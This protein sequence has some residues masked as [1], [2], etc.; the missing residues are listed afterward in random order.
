MSRKN[1]RR[2]GVKNNH[3]DHGGAR[4][5][6]TPPREISEEEFFQNLGHNINVMLNGPDVRPESVK[7]GFVLLAFPLSDI[8]QPAR[9]SNIQ[10]EDVDKVLK[11]AAG[12]GKSPLILPGHIR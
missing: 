3:K 12:G 9:L 2:R 6:P 8:T 5:A 7:V 1:P 4:N 10:T 11:H